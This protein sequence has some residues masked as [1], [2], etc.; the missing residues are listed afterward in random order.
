MSPSKEFLNSLLTKTEDEARAMCEQN[1]FRYRI[2]KIG[3]H[4]LPCTQDVKFDR[5]NVWVDKGLIVGVSA[6]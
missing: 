4:S 5:V 6:G 3:S 1:Y 2:V